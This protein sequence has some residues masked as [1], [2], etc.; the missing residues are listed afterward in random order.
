MAI[1]KQLLIYV[2]GFGG[3]GF[4]NKGQIL[5]SRF[6]NVASLSLPQ[7]P[8]L[9]IHNLE[10]F[11]QYMDKKEYD[12]VLVGSSLGGFY[13]I[14]IGEKYNLKTILINPSIQPYL[15][16]KNYIGMNKSFY[17]QSLYE[18]NTNHT[19]SLHQYEVKNIKDQTKYLLML[20]TQDEILDYRVAL[21][22]LPQ[23]HKD[24]YEGG[25]HEYKILPQKLDVIQNFLQ[26]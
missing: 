25:D 22:K 23:A 17:D 16:A 14:Y 20:T 5:R 21:Q 3:S 9:A 26:N 2:H 1:K 11:I 8:N 10:Q 24:I 4:S 18:W 13:S 7:I 12:P 6:Q 19:D 15:T